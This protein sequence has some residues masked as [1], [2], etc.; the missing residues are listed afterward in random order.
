MIPTYSKMVWTEIL[1]GKFQSVMDWENLTKICTMD[2]WNLINLSLSI[3]IIISG[4]HSKVWS[5]LVQPSIA[6]MSPISKSIFP[7]YIHISGVFN[8]PFVTGLCRC[9]YNSCDLVWLK[10]DFRNVVIEKN[11]ATCFVV[12]CLIICW[13]MNGKHPR[14]WQFKGCLKIWK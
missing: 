8:N 1:F 6:F 7:K 5:N 4:F 11:F 14:S 2:I 10:R 9:S 13:E 12:S 3:M